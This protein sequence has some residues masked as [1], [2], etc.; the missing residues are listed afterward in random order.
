[1]TVPST[2]GASSFVS[3][4][5]AVVSAYVAAVVVVVVVSAAVVVVLSTLLLLPEQ[6]ATAQIAMHSTIVNVIFFF[7]NDLLFYFPE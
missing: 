4:V 6:P 1:M 5:A 7:I 3:V 2:A